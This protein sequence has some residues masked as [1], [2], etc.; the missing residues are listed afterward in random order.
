MRSHLR[1]FYLCK[2]VTAKVILSLIRRS[3]FRRVANMPA[4]HII[5]ILYILYS[6]YKVDYRGTAAP[7][8]DESSIGAE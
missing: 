3:Y 8:K 7:N 1:Q 5:Y 4:H 6:V 2:N